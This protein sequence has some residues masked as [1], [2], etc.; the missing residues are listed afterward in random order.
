MRGGPERIQWLEP[1][2]HGGLSTIA[3]NGSWTRPENSPSTSVVVALL[4]HARLISLVL[5]SHLRAH[6]S[7]A[8]AIDDAI[9]DD[10]PGEGGLLA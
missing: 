8:V 2:R 10:V 5:H 7:H 1:P 3:S 9:D 4:A 6:G